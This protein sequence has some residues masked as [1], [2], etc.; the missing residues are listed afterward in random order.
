MMAK[1][2]S[3]QTKDFKDFKLKSAPA[4]GYFIK[5]FTDYNLLTREEAQGKDVIY[6]PGGDVTIHFS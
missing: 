6:R 1:R 5:R 2:D 4:L 3:F